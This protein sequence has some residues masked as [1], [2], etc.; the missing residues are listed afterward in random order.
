MPT[1]RNALLAAARA[2]AL[3]LLPRPAAAGF[4]GPRF[5]RTRLGAIEL[6]V[7]NDGHM[8]VPASALARHA[9]EAVIG[10]FLAARALPPTRVDFH[11]NVALARTTAGLVLIDAGAGLNWEPTAV[12]GTRLHFA[13]SRDLTALVLLHLYFDWD[14]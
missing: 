8:N 14:V 7:L 9:G 3:T 6:T 13:S 10:A 5:H 11:L 4:G 2:S 1:R 12:L